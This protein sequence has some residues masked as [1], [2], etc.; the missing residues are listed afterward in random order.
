M[1]RYGRDW[2]RR[3]SPGVCDTLVRTLGIN[4][5]TRHGTRQKGHCIWQRAI[6]GPNSPDKRA[7]VLKGVP[8]AKPPKQ[9]SL[10]CSRTNMSYTQSPD[11]SEARLAGRRLC[12]CLLLA[13]ALHLVGLAVVEVPIHQPP[14]PR[15]ALDLR[16]VSPAAPPAATVSGAV[17]EASAPT[18]TPAESAP[19]RPKTPP[20]QPHPGAPETPQ[21][22]APVRPFAGKSALELAQAVAASGATPVPAR[23][24]RVL[25]LTHAPA[26]ADFAFYLEAW[27][28]QVE[29]IGRL[30]YPGEARARKLTGTLR[31]LAV[32]DADGTLR[33]AKLMESSGHAV[34]DEAALRIVRLAAP[35]APFPPRIRAEADTLEIERT[36][37]FAG[38]GRALL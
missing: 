30:N 18:P 3:N 29:R 13:G 7:V 10:P 33:D 23:T 35:F 25:R 38:P 16:L 26:R 17:P 28:R 37:R 27:R 24:Q 21:A 2:R 15:A 8:G 11:A 36:W 31:L 4:A 20:G 1:T 6:Q 19:L 5:R 9:I 14:S 32:I 12:L 22:Q 34:L